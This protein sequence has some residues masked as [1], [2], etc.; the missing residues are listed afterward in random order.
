M[1][2]KIDEWYKFCDELKEV[3]RII[4]ETSDNT[5]DENE[6]FRYVLRLLRLST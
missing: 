1:N 6:G 3:G 4:N 5:I 2:S